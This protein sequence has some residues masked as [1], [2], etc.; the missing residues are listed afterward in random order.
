MI[1]PKK[2]IEQRKQKEQLKKDRVEQSELT[3]N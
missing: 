1:D 2:I 3:S